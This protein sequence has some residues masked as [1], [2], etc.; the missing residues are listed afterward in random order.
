MDVIQDRSRCMITYCMCFT[1][2]VLTWLK[3]GKIIHSMDINNNLL[4]IC[5]RPDAHFVNI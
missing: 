3:I 2:C 5:V 4:A 1:P